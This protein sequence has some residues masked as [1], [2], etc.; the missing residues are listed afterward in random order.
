[1]SLVRFSGHFL[2][3]GTELFPSNLDNNCLDNCCTVA[4]DE[5][6]SHLKLGVEATLQ[7]PCVYFLL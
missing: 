5:T 2:V 3:M 7:E 1:M 6:H 4:S